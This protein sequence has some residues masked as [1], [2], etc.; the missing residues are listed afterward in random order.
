VFEIIKNRERAVCLQGRI[1]DIFSVLHTRQS[2]LLVK[3][4]WDSIDIGGKPEEP[5]EE[6]PPGEESGDPTNDE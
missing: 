1:G 6:P 4:R 2:D 3:R 5:P